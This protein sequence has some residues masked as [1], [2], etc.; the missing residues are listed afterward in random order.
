MTTTEKARAA[1][2][3][4]REPDVTFANVP[5]AVRQSIADTIEA[6]IT[7]VGEGREICE[8]E[9]CGRN[10][11][12]LASRDAPAQAQAAHAAAASCGVTQPTL[13][14]LKQYVKGDD[15]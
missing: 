11:W 7:P 2:K 4:L 8:C 5:N 3:A 1:I 15:Q 9:K 14:H 6:L 10:H 12:R 13:W